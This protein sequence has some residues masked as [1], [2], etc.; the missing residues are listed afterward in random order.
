MSNL[1]KYLNIEDLRQEARR[2]LPRGVF[3]Y[4]D[5]GSEDLVSLANNREAFRL[6]KMY[7][8]IMNDVS[9]MDLATSLFGQ[10]VSLPLAVAPTAISGLCWYEGEVELARA[11]RDVGVPF[12][13]STNS[14]TPLEKVAREAG[15]NL[16]F[17]LYMWRERELSYRLVERARDSGYNTLLVSA[18]FGRGSLREKIKRNGF[19]VPYRI[20]ARS[21]ADMLMHPRWFALVMLRYMM[22]SGMP[23]NENFPEE[24]KVRITADPTAR[25]ALRADSLVWEDVDRLR[26]RWQG[27]LLVKGVM[28]PEDARLALQHGA[29]G[30]VV[31]NHGGRN[32]DSSIASIDVLPEIVDAV[33][34]RMTV[35]LDSGVRRG[36][37]IA[38]AIA[39]GAD[40]V[41]VG[42]APLY[43]VT[44]GGKE[45]AKRALALL[46]NELEKTMAFLGCRAID[47]LNRGLIARPRLS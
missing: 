25:S 2:I 33:G 6:V 36:S 21:V 43:G 1:K 12:I 47:E 17:Q 31:S 13:L 35:I 44:V 16:W 26:A 18:D 23:R 40:S 11:A 24:Y 37:D 19:S 4:M 28:H 42:R 29:D 27:P 30:I 5:S 7:S 32:M 15:G 22:T 41:L 10:P 9:S 45:G 34:G 3:E 20:S 46:A 14:I 38:K 39:M 8:R